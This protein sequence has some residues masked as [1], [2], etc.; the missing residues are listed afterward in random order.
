MAVIQMAKNT[1]N[2]T[3]EQEKKSGQVTNLFCHGSATTESGVPSLPAGEGSQSRFLPKRK[4][5]VTKSIVVPAPST[6]T[7]QLHGLAR[8]NTSEAADLK[9]SNRKM[10]H[11]RRPMEAVAGHSPRWKHDKLQ[12]TGRL[13]K[14]VSLNTA[15]L[16][17]AVVVDLH[18][19]FTQMSGRS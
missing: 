11:C 8:K 18:T 6:E 17:K 16:F 5:E 13:E 1:A 2:P 3:S 4:Y 7:A 12:T 19:L 14:Y 10:N 9:G 15:K